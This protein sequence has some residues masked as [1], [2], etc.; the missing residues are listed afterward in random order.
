MDDLAPTIQWAFNALFT[1]VAFLGGWIMSS[2]QRSVDRLDTDVR[3]MPEKYVL[4]S[5][6]VDHLH[7]IRAGLLRI[8][9][10]IDEKADK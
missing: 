1:V 3:A 5:D 10:K 9:E 4:K 7:E 8:E 2:F 6:Y